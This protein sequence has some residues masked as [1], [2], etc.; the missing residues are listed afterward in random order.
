MRS[1]RHEMTRHELKQ[2]KFLFYLNKTFA[3]MGKYKEK[4]IIFSVA[5][6]AIVIAAASFNY[7]KRSTETNAYNALINAKAHL[8]KG[9]FKKAED[10]LKQVINKHIN[11][12]AGT[13]ALF[14]L[15]SYYFNNKE[16]D[17]CLE[18]TD[19][20]LK[21]IKKKN[22]LYPKLLSYQ[23]YCYEQQEKY[24]YAIKRYNEFIENFPNIYLTPDIYLALARCYDKQNIKDKSKEIIKIIIE[25]YPNTIWAKK[26]EELNEQTI[27]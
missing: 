14:Y 25:K 21:K 24:D 27:I 8:D 22:I 9:E 10:E 7:H 1:N 5:F 19:K 13:E 20:A 3:Y 18:L 15:A 16:Y 4:I 17:K 26:A 6:V 12:D 2:D 11:I 23:G